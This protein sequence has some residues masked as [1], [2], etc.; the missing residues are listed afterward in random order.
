MSQTLTTDEKQTVE[1]SRSDMRALWDHGRAVLQHPKGKPL[2]HRVIAV[3]G[4]SW[5]EARLV[6]MEHNNE[7]VKATYKT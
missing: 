4:S 2:P 3:H 7:H 6:H 5:I 1:V